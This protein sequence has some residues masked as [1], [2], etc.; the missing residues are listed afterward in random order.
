MLSPPT[1][2]DLV[3]PFFCKVPEASLLQQ[4]AGRSSQAFVLSKL[5][6][7]KRALVYLPLSFGA[8]RIGFASVAPDAE[9]GCHSLYRAQQRAGHR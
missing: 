4:T 6:K 7:H 5:S 9:R 3:T 8:H 1:I 2:S